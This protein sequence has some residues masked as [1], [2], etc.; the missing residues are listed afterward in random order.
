MLSFRDKKK[1]ASIHPM[2]SDLDSTSISSNNNYS[3]SSNGSSSTSSEINQEP[4][5]SLPLVPRRNSSVW[6]GSNKVKTAT[7]QNFERNGNLEDDSENKEKEN[8]AEDVQQQH[9]R[10]W[11]APIDLFSVIRKNSR[12]EVERSRRRKSFFVEWGPC[13]EIDAEEG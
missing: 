9:E 11:D 2:D 5:P 1:S 7:L 3:S 6:F 10:N 13:S 8:Y 4:P 12:E